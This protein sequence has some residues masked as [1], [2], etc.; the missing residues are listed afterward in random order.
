VAAAAPDFDD[1]DRP[2]DDDVA[3]RAAPDV[4]AVPRFEPATLVFRNLRYKVRAGREAELELL[5]GVTGYATPGTMTCLM[6]SSGAGKTTLLDVVAARKT[7]GS[8]EGEITVNGRPQ[9]PR[10][11]AKIAAYVEQLDVHQ[12]PAA[13][14][15]SSSSVVRAVAR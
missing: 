8:I 15:N 13:V 1:D 5:G 11:L 2:V 10:A 3:E 6:G 14:S 9:T 12:P 4:A 7:S